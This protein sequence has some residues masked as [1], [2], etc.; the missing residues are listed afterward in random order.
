MPSRP[1]VHP[2][3][4]P[5]HRRD[6]RREECIANAAT[7]T[8]DCFPS[9]LTLSRPA[10]LPAADKA[11]CILSSP[12]SCKARRVDLIA[13]PKAQWACG[14]LGWT[15]SAMFN[16]E[17][18]RRAKAVYNYVLTSHHLCRLDKPYPHNVIPVSSETD[19]FEALGLP[20]RAPP[21]RAV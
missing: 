4:A 15:G 2:T 5:A 6:R 7:A 20:Y 11:L 10:C 19:V 12:V 16:R 13:I 17:L 8:P 18:R 1:R 14:L 9:G 3:H 21:L